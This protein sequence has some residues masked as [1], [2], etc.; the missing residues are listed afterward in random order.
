MLALA[1]SCAPLT[2]C[3]HLPFFHR[4]AGVPRAARAS[5]APAAA[6]PVRLVS[7]DDGDPYR[8]SAVLLAADSLVSAEGALRVLLARNPDNAAALALLSKLLFRTG[9][10]AEAVALLQP[11]ASRPQAFTDAAR[12]ALLAGLALHEDALGRTDDARTTLAAARAIDG[13][14]VSSAD[15]YLLLRGDAP[16]SAAAPARELLRR[17]GSSAVHHNNAGIT[18]LRAGDLDGARREFEVAMTRDPALPGP[19]YNLAILE[20]F[21]RFDDTAAARWF[22]AYWDR[23]HDDPDSLRAAFPGNLAS[24]PVPTGGRP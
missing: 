15:V 11:V 6:T 19:Y 24:V 3:A 13:A 9:R 17:D 21:Y 14:R 10:H 20:K 12:A 7:R 4:G 16:D 5:H 2:G 23:S 22:G 8:R 1:L 18:R